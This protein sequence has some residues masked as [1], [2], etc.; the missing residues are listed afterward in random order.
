MHYAIA[1]FLLAA[2]SL[3]TSALPDV[4]PSSNT[5]SLRAREAVSAGATPDLAH[6]WCGVHVTQYQKN[7]GPKGSGGGTI[8]YR[9]TVTL[10]DA[11]QDP[12]GGVTLLSVPGGEYV[13]IDS[14]LPY[15]FDVEVGGVDSEPVFFK[16]ASQS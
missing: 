11:I 2:L 7:E 6:G 3:R 10:K 8:D 1:A 4:D 16:Y 5:P 15:V 9:L 13:G 14:Q 12:I